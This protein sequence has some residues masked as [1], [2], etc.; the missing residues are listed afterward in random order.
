MLRH[1]CV[2]RKNPYTSIHQIRCIHQIYRMYTGSVYEM[3]H[4]TAMSMNVVGDGRE[5]RDVRG[6]RRVREEVCGVEVSIGRA[7]VLF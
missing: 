2:K 7:A 4:Y 3:R 6:R 5:E 1:R